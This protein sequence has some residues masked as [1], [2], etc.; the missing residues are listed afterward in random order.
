VIV[1]ALGGVVVAGAFLLP[2][3]GGS[4]SVLAEAARRTLASGS[5]RTT[6]E[7]TDQSTVEDFRAPDRLRTAYTVQRAHGETIVVGRDAFTSATFCPGTEGFTHHRLPSTRRGSGHALLTA[8]TTQ[9]AT[10]AISGG[11]RTR[12]DVSWT[13]ASRRT[14]GVDVEVVRAS[15]T[16][17]RGRVRN[18]TLV[19]RYRT[20]RQTVN[21]TE[22]FAFS[23]FG[24]VGP[25]AA[26][27]SSQLLP[28][29][30]VCDLGDLTSGTQ[31]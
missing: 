16:T 19:L 5:F 2:H 21:M 4:Q 13:P 14:R 7:S 12:Y 10:T 30:F 18:A 15:A 23:R 3:G 6:I 26:P 17:E 20:D 1:A 11:G 31:R 24:T 27:P 8:L 25:I 28:D 29:D 22:H 9:P